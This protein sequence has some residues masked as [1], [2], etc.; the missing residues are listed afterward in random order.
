M[1][2]LYTFGLGTINFFWFI[3]FSLTLIFAF[4]SPNLIIGD[5]DVFGTST[6]FVTTGLIILLLGL[7]LSIVMFPRFRQKLSWLF[8][9]K[10][11]ASAIVLLV[12]VVL[13]QVLF[14]YFVHPGSGFD[15]GMLNYAA[16]SKEH[17]LEAEVRGYFSLNQN[18]LP[19][20]LLMRKMVEVTGQTSWQ[21]F[22]YITLLFVDL[23][24]LL[25]IMTVRVIAPRATAFSI[26]LQG[27]WLLVFPS[28]LKPY[29][30]TW[31]LPL[32]SG[33]LLC[34][35]VVCSKRMNIVLRVVAGGLLGP[36]VAL[37]YFIKPSAIIPVIAIILIGIL[38]G[39]ARDLSWNSRGLAIGIT[40]LIT[41]A[42][43]GTYQVI[44]HTIENQDYIQIDISRNIP[45]IHFASMGITGTGGYSAEQALAMAG[46]P[47]KDEKSAYSKEI[48]ANRLKELGFGGYLS[49]LVKKHNAN[50][51]DGTFGWLKE[52]NFFIENQKPSQKGIANKLKNFI[53]LYGENIADFRFVTQ[54]VWLFC[55]LVIL[56]GHGKVTTGIWIMRLSLVGAFL[57]L[58]LFEGGRSRYLIQF[59]PCFILLAALSWT[60]AKRN[61]Q[62]II[63]WWHADQMAKEKEILAEK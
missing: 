33:Y 12:L 18:N 35:F 46:L 4:L 38:R 20:M 36:L 44:N 25:N 19:I 5:N 8:I 42:G 23:S 24:V 60:N 28:I 48:I 45:M 2:K 1:K 52:G 13:L 55:L 37:T 16:V 9:T 51:A 53:F 31:V 43:S 15:A 32:V 58:L 11:Y 57:F 63:D 50:T 3:F 54:L 59:L 30:D 22:D 7:L 6:T 40:A 62:K 17:V 39:I 26:Y 49:F 34:Y 10:K 56:F 47:T 21:F 29:T 61:V 14:L 41:V 27:I